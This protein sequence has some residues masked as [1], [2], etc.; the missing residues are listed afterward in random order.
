MYLSMFTHSFLP[1]KML[2]GQIKPTLKNGSICKTNSENYRPVMNSSMFLKLFEYCLVNPIY[3][4]IDL[5]PLQFGFTNNSSCSKAITLIKETILYYNKNGSNVHG[6]SIDLSKAFDK[7]NIRILIDKLKLTNVP[8]PIIRI[9]SYMLHNTYVNVRYGNLIGNEFLVRNGVR[10]GGILSSTL[11]NIYLDSCISK[12]SSMDIGCQLNYEKVNLIA[13]ADD[14]FAIVPSATGLQQVINVIYQHL[15]ELC[16]HMN[17]DKS[18]YIVFNAKRNKRTLSEVKLNNIPL[19]RVSNVKYL[20]VILSEDFSIN[21]DIDRAS[22]S[23]LKQFNSFYQKFNFLSSDIKNFLFKTYCTSFYGCETWIDEPLN[24][25]KLRK[26]AVSYHKAVKKVAYMAPWQSNHEACE[27]VKVNIFKH[28][29]TKRMLNHFYSLLGSNNVM[30]LKMRYFL[31]YQSEIK[32]KL[33]KSFENIYNVNNFLSN[34]KCAL[35]SRIDYVE[36]N[37]P[38]SNYHY[39]LG[40]PQVN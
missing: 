17:M 2:M 20:G 19:K 7:I 18:V 15:S 28:L 25:N 40:G 11:F 4:G 1:K 30:L 22:S 36:R 9:I 23:F 5:N 12:I 33:E 3:S 6:A 13:Y 26:V 39:N 14:L 29:V 21:K 27:K 10:Q 8:L 24:D 37:E 32:E 16:L 38:R 31:R 34:D 35:L